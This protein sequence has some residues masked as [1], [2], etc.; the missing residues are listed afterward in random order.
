MTNGMTPRQRLEAVFSLQAPDRTPALGGWIANPEAIFRI[1]EASEDDYYDDIEGVSIRAYQKLGCDGLVGIF[2]P[3]ARGAYR[4][5]NH[6]SYVKA[7]FGESLEVSVEW[8]EAMDPPETVEEEFDFEARYAEYKAELIR[9]QARCGKMVWMPANWTA[10]AKATWF[11][12]FGYENFL[13][14]TALYP[15]HVRKLWEIGGARARCAS[16]MAAKAFQEGLIPRAILLGEDLCTQRGPIMSVAMI[17]QH[18]APNLRYGLQPLL[19]AGMRPV[20][21]SD[22]DVRRLMDMLIDCGIKGFQGFQPECGMLIEEIV[23]R[24]TTEGDPLIIFGPMA[25]T[26]ELPVMTA[27]EVESR[28]KHVIRLCKDMAAL[29]LFSSN[30]INPD[31]PIEN[32]QA[33]YGAVR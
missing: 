21:H 28:V 25:V 22:G 15:D 10:G 9:V 19:E 18:Y 30:T 17:E 6:D 16:R 4:N 12:Q 24:R 33:M 2:K 26:T 3:I 31:V 27:Q 5:V 14:M 32:I 1:A 7:N 23:K 11:D 29:V 8:V 20:W 13:M